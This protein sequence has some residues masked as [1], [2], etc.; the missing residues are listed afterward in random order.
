MP[1]ESQKTLVI[2]SYTTWSGFQ[3]CQ[4]S[5]LL[6]PIGF[7]CILGKDKGVVE[8]WNFGEPGTLD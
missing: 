3:L 5:G 8:S 6:Y 1:T 2:G 4:D 7:T